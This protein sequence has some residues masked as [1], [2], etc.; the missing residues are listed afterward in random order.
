MQK[1]IVV[2]LI[3]V[4]LSLLFPHNLFSQND[5]FDNVRLDFQRRT[6][7]PKEVRDK[8]VEYQNR[9][10]QDFQQK[11]QYLTF[12]YAYMP[13][14][15][16][17]DYDLS[18]FEE[19]VD[20]ACAARKTFSWGKSLPEDV[21]RHFVLVY[22]VNNENL[23][24]AR[25]YIFHQLKDRIKN[26]N[27]YDAALEVN[28]WCHEHVD[29][30]PS[31]ARTSAPLAT[32]RTSYGRCGE[33][34]TLTVTA[35][36]AVG[37]PA[38]Q[39]YTPRWAHCDDN[40]AWVEVWI[41]G[42]WYFLGACEPAPALNMGWFDNVST[43]TMMVH[44]NVFG[45]Y[46]GS[47]EV[48]KVTPYYSCINLLSNYADTITAY[49]T[50]YD[51]LHRPAK[52]ASVCF[53]LYNYA[54]YYTLAEV[55]TDEYGRAKLN[56]GL[57]D[58]LVWAK[59]G[60]DFAY[61]KLDLRKQ[62]HLVLILKDKDDYVDA[63]PVFLSMNPPKGKPIVNHVSTAARISC[64][65][66][67]SK[68]DK[69]RE[70]Y[71]ATFPTKSQ[72]QK[73]KNENFSVEEYSDIIRRSEGNYLEI[74]TFLQAHNKKIDNLFL[75]DFIK[76]LADKD[77]RDTKANVLESHLTYF[78]NSNYPKEIYIQGILPARISNELI[79]SWRQPLKAFFNAEFSSQ[80]TVNKMIEWTKQ[81]IFIDP[82]CNY[83][84]CPISPE[85][86]LKT[87]RS[88]AHSRD[89]FF[90]AACRSLN[91]PA[92]LDNASNVIYAWQNS[93]WQ[94]VTFE[95]KE[96]EPNENLAT[97]TLHNPNNLTYYIHYTLQRFENGEYVSYDFENDPRVENKHIV[98]NLPAGK[99]CLS[100]GN[101]YSNGDV[102][103]KLNFFEMKEKEK[104]KITISIPELTPRNHNYGL[105]K[106]DAI[107][108][109]G[110]SINEIIAESGKEKVIICLVNPGSEPTNHLTKEISARKTE[111]EKWG[112]KIIFVT[113]GKK[114]TKEENQPNNLEVYTKK[115]EQMVES[116]NGIL[117]NAVHDG[118]LTH[119]TGE[120]PVCLVVDKTGTIS[121]LSE[122]YLIGL[123]ELLLGEVEK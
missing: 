29:Y 52:E 96:V 35:M 9:N 61:A 104:K 106:V 82:L 88:D 79:R 94:E 22:R 109:N 2:A 26:L 116:V 37:I 75:N 27:M 78:N 107:S 110:K 65:K 77:L 114:W 10:G 28:H 24:T 115:T 111:Y 101:R 36:R 50:V 46:N 98:L 72:L 73:V 20:I 39:C 67:L 59:D 44:T 105:L 32:L 112:G 21:F 42:K 103:S 86:V 45:K 11:A 41:D 63:I 118:A 40:H 97:L 80:P 25:S 19:Q 16:L 81:N 70:A 84:N 93:D 48:N 12:L 43:R 1:N 95:Q 91:I 47:E 99:Y 74:N 5:Y 108:I 14:S 122:G 62:N 57:G 60:N 92:Y 31:D 123:G 64:E 54:E 15:D 119:S 18:F 90:V 34:S 58:L 71:R 3:C 76:S 6:D 69:M 120:K 102:V 66:R 30:Q 89:I 23:D 17:A 8:I 113:E 100:S 33:E 4:L 53:K 83:Y 68:E 87:R 55:K 13:Q 38:R 51:K 49:V 56:T 85:G 117:R 7:I 121:F